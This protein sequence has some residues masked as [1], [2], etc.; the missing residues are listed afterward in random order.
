MPQQF[1]FTILKAF[2][3]DCP[4]R[5]ILWNSCRLCYI[6]IPYH[7]SCVHPHIRPNSCYK[8]HWAGFRGG[9]IEPEPEPAG[10]EIR[11]ALTRT[12][13]TANLRLEGGITLLQ[14]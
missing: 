3:M 1:T 11:R 2:T 13:P 9:K 5:P 10:P 4:P 14:K 8:I 12:C 7:P 6:H